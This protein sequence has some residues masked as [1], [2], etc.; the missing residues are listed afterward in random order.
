[1]SSRISYFFQK[2]LALLRVRATAAGLEVNDQVLRLAAFDGKIWQM[3]AIRLEPGVLENGRIKDR[4][5]LIAALVALK[6][7]LGGGRDKAKKL[8]VVVAMSSVETYTQV[9]SLPVVQ[10]KDLDQAV[11]LNLQMASPL[12]AGEAYYGWQDLGRNESGLQ[13]EILST[14]VQH[15]AVDEM[16]DALFEAGFLAMAVESR[17]L[18]LTR[19]L[20]EKGAGVDVAKPYLF[21]NIDNSGIDFLIIRNGSLHFEYATP[22]RDLMDE[23]GEIAV[24]KFET[25]LA[26]SVRQV[27]NFY[28]Q[29]WPDSLSTIILSAVALQEQAEKVIALNAAIPAARLTL[30]MGQPISSEWLMALGSSLRGTGHKIKSHEINLL[31]DDSRDRFHEEQLLHFLRFWRA[32]VPGALVLLVIT[33]GVADTFL[34]KTRAEIES[35]SDFSLTGTQTS[36]IGALQESANVFNASVALIAATESGL[37]PKGVILERLLEVGTPK[38]VTI[39]TLSFQSYGAPI[40]ISGSAFAEDAVVAFKEE[41]DHDP[42]FTA[43]NLP[44]NGVQR[45]GTDSVTFSMTFLYNPTPGGSP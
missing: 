14:F 7:K 32:I 26:A 40:S 29:H 2:L 34:S 21:V 22:W 42:H 41:L 10:G 24:P 39:N 36:E 44:L 1:M 31:G 19:V 45:Q 20:R 25:A 17:A 13:L 38:R 11:A 6:A 3:H 12:E 23:K 33:F 18:A 28:T 27:L 9:F 43:V 35:H 15:K 16:V 5:L 4:A 37:K 8:N 30:V